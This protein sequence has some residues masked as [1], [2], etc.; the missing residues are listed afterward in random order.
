MHSQGDSIVC[1]KIPQSKPAKQRNQSQKT[2]GARNKVDNT[3]RNIKP[4]NQ[5]EYLQQQGY[6]KIVVYFC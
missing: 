2:N 3:T 1:A 5:L 6:S 4:L